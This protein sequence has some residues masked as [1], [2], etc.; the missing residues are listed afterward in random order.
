MLRLFPLFRLRAFMFL[1]VLTSV[2]IFQPGYASADSTTFYL[3]WTEGDS[4]MVSQ[5]YNGTT[6]QANAYY[7]IDFWKPGVEGLPVTASADGVVVKVVN[8]FTVSTWPNKPTL[9]GNVVILR[10]DDGTYTQYCHLQKENGQPATGS[11]GFVKVGE[12]IKRGTRIGSVGT[13][14]SASGAHLHFQRQNGDSENSQ[15]IPVNF[16]DAPGGQV[17]DYN[18]YTPSTPKN[19]ASPS[20]PTQPAAKPGLPTLTATPPAAGSLVAPKNGD[21]LSNQSILFQWTPATDYVG[22]A[23][24]SL[25]VGRTAD[26]VGNS[27]DL[28]VSYSSDSSDNPLQT[29][30]SATVNETSGTYYW[31]I[32]ARNKSGLAVTYDQGTFSLSIRFHPVDPYRLMINLNLWLNLSPRI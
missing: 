24:Y 7:G 1:F 4:W 19:V 17:V 9:S 25:R 30:Y 27:S 12:R 26:L 8:S 11:N 13:T 16:A 15:S 32:V 18:W 23:S 10:H 20:S 21:L 31:T 5:G 28:I 6:H 14:G 2:L 29:S 3:P 22:I